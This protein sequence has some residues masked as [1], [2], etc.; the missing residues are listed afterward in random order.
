MDM[1]D[2]DRFAQDGAIKGYP[3]NKDHYQIVLDPTT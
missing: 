1:C 2:T 3:I